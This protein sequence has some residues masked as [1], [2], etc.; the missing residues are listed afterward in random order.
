ME[1]KLHKEF[2]D[3]RG[4]IYIVKD[5]LENNKEFSFLELKKGAARGGCLHS[6]NEFYVVVKGKLRYVH[7]GK[8]EIVSAGQSGQIVAGEPHAFFALEDSFVSE[9]GIT[10]EEKKKDVKDPNLRKTVDEFNSKLKS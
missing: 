6:N 4:A 9:W 7:G 5:L 8:E 3:K 1:A 10:T 2:E